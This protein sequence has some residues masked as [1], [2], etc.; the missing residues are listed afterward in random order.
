MERRRYLVE[1]IYPEGNDGYPI[2][3]DYV[4]ATSEDEARAKVEKVRQATD[5][6]TFDRAVTFEDYIAE[7]QARIERL[8]NMTEA[9]VEEGWTE[10]MG[11]LNC[12]PCEVC[13]ESLD[14]NDGDNWDDLCPGCADLVSDHM[15]RALVNR[16]AAI[17]AVRESR[18]EIGTAQEG[19]N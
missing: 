8:T 3:G 5:E 2:T 12:G 7:M 15:D 10:T 14:P 13:G 18:A 17:E 1:G 16:D 6:W 11:N 19:S 9:Q 4:T